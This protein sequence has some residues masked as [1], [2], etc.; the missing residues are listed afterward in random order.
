MNRW[1]KPGTPRAAPTPTARDL[2][3]RR[4]AWKAL[5]EL[6]LDN[7]LHFPSVIRELRA[8]GLSR[9][10]LKTIMDTEVAPVLGSNLAGVAG[11]W[12]AF[13]LTPVEQRYL[14]GKARR[15]LEGRYALWLVGRTWQRVLR[16][17]DTRPP[18]S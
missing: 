2:E 8:T 5:S 16:G 17:V 3:V 6:F 4:Q 11:E 1:R 14:V 12:I 9:A 13:D 10:E 15:T 7:E 18:G